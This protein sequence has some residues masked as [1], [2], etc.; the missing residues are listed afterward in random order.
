MKM[1]ELRI[2]ADLLPTTRVG[3]IVTVRVNE[4]EYRCRIIRVDGVDALVHP[5]ERLTLPSESSLALSLVQVLPKKE[6]MELIIEK[7]TELGVNRIIPCVSA[8]STTLAERDAVQKKSLRWATVARKAAEQSRR[9]GIP[10]I[11]DCVDFQSAIDLASDADIKIILYEK[12]LS[13]RLHDL[14]PMKP[15]SLAIVAGAEGG[16]AEEEIMLARTRQFIPVRLGGR[17]LRAETAGIAAISI[18]QF[19]WGDL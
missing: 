11:E 18:A 9:R 15:T 6:K 17:T 4:A 7:A 16:F 10:A 8:K 19:L 5:F 13:A 2:S 1:E 14:M 12:E 3:A